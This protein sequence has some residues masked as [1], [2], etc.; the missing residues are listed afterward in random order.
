MATD[1][2]K[3]QAKTP[4][5]SGTTDFS[6]YATTKNVVTETQQPQEGYLSR[7]LGSFGNLAQQVTQ[8][9]QQG[10][11]AYQQG[12]DKGTFGGM[13]EATGGLLRSGLRTVGTVASGAFTPITEAPVIKPLLEKGVTKALEIPGANELVTT[14]TNLAKRYPNASKDIQNIIDIATLGTGG[15]AEKPLIQE[16]KAIASD[17]A[18]G[19]KILLTPSEETVQKNVVSMFNK[20]IKPTAKKT[21]GQAEKY[22]TH[23]VSALRTIKSNVDNLNIQDATGELVSGRA[24][25]TIPELSQALEQTKDSVFKQYDSLAKQ[26]SGVGATIDAKPIA[27]EVLKVTQNKA[28]QLTNPD[29]INY[30]EN[31]IKRLQVF[32]QL[33]TETTQEVVKLMN[34]NLE[35][36]YKNP[37]Y[38]SASKVAIDAGVANN[39]RQAL[40]KAIEG[41]TGKEY[42][43]L[44]NQYSALKSIESDVVRASLREARKN[45]KGLLDYTDIF[46]SGQM[47]GG[48]LSLNPAM[49]TKGAIERGFKE[50]LKFLNDPNRAIKNIFEKLDTGASQTFNPTSATGMYLKK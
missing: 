23:I 7:V 6:K 36:F 33:D 31:W 38:E 12:V 21:L 11:Q 19:G 17:I 1:F 20:A 49:F 16:G 40:D 37:T 45:V 29:V 47:V 9:V 34:K 32:G 35:S 41:A 42:Q 3:Y 13:L 25:Q 46:T 48:I 44:K 26:A 5:T 50:Y 22:D 43:V 14:A 28:L 39:F 27:D 8:G 15:V 2:S 30:A 4:V 10:A 24:P 18:Q